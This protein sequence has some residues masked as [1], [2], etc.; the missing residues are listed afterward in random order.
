MPDEI[1][2]GT[3]SSIGVLAESGDWSDPNHRTYT[4][5]IALDGEN[6]LG[7]KP[8]MRCQ[9]DIKIDQVEEAL[10]IPI[11]ALHRDGAQIFVYLKD[12]SGYA[13]QAVTA[14]RASE[15]YIEITEGLLEGQQVLLRE[16]AAEEITTKLPPVPDKLDV[17]KDQIAESE[18]PV[19]QPTEQPAEQPIV[20]PEITKD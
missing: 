3:V 15:L 13:Q 19:D 8:S 18:P 14:G 16:P 20:Q 4:V 1:L 17:E 9:A 5:S 12:G 10:H 7:L 6:T 2:T 11:Q